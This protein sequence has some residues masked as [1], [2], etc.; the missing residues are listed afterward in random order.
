MFKKEITEKKRK[1]VEAENSVSTEDARTIYNKAIYDV[2][3]LNYGT[4]VFEKLE[5]NEVK[6][7]KRIIA[8]TRE[9]MPKFGTKENCNHL[10][11]ISNVNVARIVEDETNPDTPMQFG[12]ADV[13]VNCLDCGMP[14]HFRGVDFGMSPNK[15]MVNVGGL[16]LRAP[17]DAGELTTIPNK[18]RYEVKRNDLF[19][20]DKVN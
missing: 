12:Y 9:M 8:A 14:F 1:I 3:P 20:S 6:A 4:R 13:S 7:F 11:F 18:M 10:N 5:E 2:S 17:I 15:P 19:E 16:E